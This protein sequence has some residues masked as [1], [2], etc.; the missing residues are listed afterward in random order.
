LEIFEAR[1]LLSVNVTTFQNDLARSGVNPNETVL[2]PSNVNSAD[3]GKLFSA[4]LDGQA[5]AQPLYMSGLT[6]SDGLVHNVVFVA[7]EHDSVHAFDADGRGGNPASPLWHDS[8]I[9]PTRGVTTVGYNDVG[10][11]DIAPEIGITGTPV[12]DSSTNTLYVVA[13]TKEVDSS[14]VIHFV[15]RLHALDVTTGAEK[16]GGPAVISDT[17]QNSDGSYT[18]WAGPSVSGTGDGSVNGVVTFNALRQQTRP[19]LLLDNGV[20]YIAFASHGDNGPYHGWVLGYNASNLQL[21]AAFN[22]TPNG[23]LGGIWQSGNGLAADASGDLY[24]I[25]GNGTFDTSLDPSTGL[26]GNGDYGD[27]VVR[28]TLDPSSTAGHQNGNPNGWGLKVADYFTPS[29]EDALNQVDEDFG[30]GGAVLLPDIGSPP[31]HLLLAAGKEGKIY[32]INRDDMGHFHT[33][34]NRVVQEI[35]GATG[36]LWGS[37]AVFNGQA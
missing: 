10:I 18:F 8:F 4:S 13:K 32:V 30:S 1:Q 28:L 16:L 22:T 17:S 36:G 25:T 35:P 34:A 37:P 26:P 27:S 23:G 24:F 19:G 2:T 14:G 29:N 3:F 5:Y 33:D 7:T 21:T 15:Q 6:M 9:D 11:H 31:Q 12:I 20:I